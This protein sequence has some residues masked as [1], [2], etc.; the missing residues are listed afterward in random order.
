M[1]ESSIRRGS[2]AIARPP[3]VRESNGSASEGV[4]IAPPP[5]AHLGADDQPTVIT[6]RA[7]APGEASSESVSR[8]LHGRILPG[9]R[10]GHFELLK[11]VGGGGM[12]KV[13]R[14]LDTR[15]ARSVALKILAPEHASDDE[16]VQ[17]F[18]NEA[19]SAAR[20]DHENI[21]RVY[22]VGEDR[23]L[24]YIVF[25][26]IE[27]VN[28]RD[29]V[30]N[31]GPLPLAEAV[32]YA[33]QVADALAHA[34]ERNVV[35][36]DI[37]P[38]NLLITPGGQ[39]KLIDMGLARLRETD[40]AADLTAS[41]VTLGTFDYISPEQ[42]RDPRNAD[43]RSDIYSLGCTLFFMLTGRPPFVGGTMLQ[44]LLQHQGDQPPDL[45][46]FRPDLPDEVNRILRKMLAKDPRHRY[47]TPTELVDELI[48]VARAAG[49]RPTAPGGR[50]WAV[51]RTTTVPRFYWHLPWIVSLLALVAIVA[52]LGRLW[53][54]L[55]GPANPMPAPE[56]HIRDGKPAGMATPAPTGRRVEEAPRAAAVR[57][58]PSA[59]GSGSKTSA[60]VVAASAGT[61]TNTESAAEKQSKTTAEAASKLLPP[62]GAL[63]KSASSVLTPPGIET[64]GTASVAIPS[65]S[66]ALPT[67]A[68]PDE[69]RPDPSTQRRDDQD[70]WGDSGR[71]P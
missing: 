10:L 52:V 71:G 53:P 32:S 56:T 11:Y 70:F 16:T 3:D 15:L 38:S 14:A 36:R 17:R 21:A 49:L 6:S 54:Y 27:G 50:T 35:H 37:K 19:Q 26:F 51:P 28:V 66:A 68:Q 62:V 47:A 55:P 64:S 63:D 22:Y 57:P 45:H 18:Q 41:G 48:V 69:Q 65:S 13:F 1:P 5:V 23:G 24:H 25:E 42:A 29:L 60:P 40:S 59:T 30:V 7:A 46:Q 12:G 44:K 2:D 33:L 43:V 39:A 67:P 20:L 4:V 34:S 31:R 61:A 58:L 8:I 9:E